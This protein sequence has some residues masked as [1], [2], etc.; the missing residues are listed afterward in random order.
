MGLEGLP[1][2]STQHSEHVPLLHRP[3]SRLSSVA[4]API[5]IC[6]SPASE[7]GSACSNHG[8]HSPSRPGSSCSKRSGASLGSTGSAGIIGTCRICLEQE[9]RDSQD[10]DNPLISPCLCSGGS[11]YVHRHCLQQWRQTAHR[12]DA[13][14]QCEVCKYR[15][16]YQRLWWANLLGSQA[17]LIIMFLLAMTATI[18]VLG[19]IPVTNSFFPNSSSSSTGSYTAKIAIH[20]INGVILMGLMGLVLSLMLQLGRAFGLPALALLPEP[21]CPSCIWCMQEGGLGWAPFIECGTAGECGLALLVV[22]AVVMLVVG[23]VMA[24]YMLYGLLWLLVQTGLN[25]AQRMVENVQH[26]EQQVTAK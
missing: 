24:A 1:V 17:T 3:E 21:W 16:R 13:Y 8:R 26:E 20:I 18:I 15:Y 4:S 5:D 2:L 11:K 22:V 14:Y 9:T 12:A 25:R 7:A 10:P 23:V 6:I 19:F